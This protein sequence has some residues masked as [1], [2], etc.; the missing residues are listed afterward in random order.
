MISTDE[1]SGDLKFTRNAR[2][3]SYL[4]SREGSTSSRAASGSSSLGTGRQSSFASPPSSAGPFMVD[5]ANPSS[6]SKSTTPLGLV[7]LIRQASFTVLFVVVSWFVPRY[8]IATETTILH[9][10]D[11]PYQETSAGDIILD[12]ELNR[13]VVDP[14]TIPCKNPIVVANTWGERLFSGT[15]HFSKKN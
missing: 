3:L 9:K 12:E 6:V 14:P 4:S 11:I 8:M 15:V 7:D 1:E 2:T 13:P 5:S 10:A